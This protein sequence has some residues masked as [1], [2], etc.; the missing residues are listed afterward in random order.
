MSPLTLART[1]YQTL[2]NNP[3]AVK[4]IRAELDSLALNMATNADFGTQITS[5]TVNGQS[6]AG[7]SVMTNLDRLAALR[8][9]ITAVD[10]GVPPSSRTQARF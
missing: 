5:A 8:A 2:K 4:A 10:T 1:L 6:Y 9:F 3:S 7:Q